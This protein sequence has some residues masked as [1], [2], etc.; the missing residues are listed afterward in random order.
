M[1]N[2][3]LALGIVSI[4]ATAS[5]AQTGKCERS[6]QVKA[7]AVAPTRG[8]NTNIKKDKVNGQRNYLKPRS[9]TRGITSKCLISFST[10][11]KQDIDIYVD[12][13]YMGSLRTQMQ[14]GV[15]ES[16]EKYESIYCLSADKKYEWKEK[17]DC[18]CIYTFELKK[19]E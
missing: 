3:I 19:Q 16:I 17:G 9:K 11:I 15:V 1:R 10:D 13:V 7:T 14:S 8:L 12:G 2:L 5:N 4:C 18:S 6:I